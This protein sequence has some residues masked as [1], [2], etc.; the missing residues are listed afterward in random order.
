M[1]DKSPKVPFRQFG[2]RFPFQDRQQVPFQQR[3]FWSEYPIIVKFQKAV[4]FLGK[5]KKNFA[6]TALREWSRF[7]RMTI[8]SSLGRGLAPFASSSILNENRMMDS[9]LTEAYFIWH[10]QSIFSSFGNGLC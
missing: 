1:K 9:D 7:L 3:P 6:H 5:A 4:S 8:G 10:A 2:L